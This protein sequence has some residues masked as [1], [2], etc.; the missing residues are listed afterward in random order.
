LRDRRKEER[1]LFVK[2]EFLQDM[3]SENKLLCSFLQKKSIINVVLWEPDLLPSSASLHSCSSGSKAPDKKSEGGCTI[4]S[5]QC[6][7][8]DKNN[9]SSDDTAYLSG[10]QC[11]SMSAD[12]KSSYAVSAS[13]EVQPKA[14]AN[15]EDYLP[16]D[17]SIDSGSLTCVACGILGFPFMAILQPSR[18]ALER[19]S[20]IH[21]KKDTENFDK[22]SS[23]LLLRCS[24][25]D[26]YG[27][28]LLQAFVISSSREGCI[29]KT[30][31]GQTLPRKSYMHRAALIL[32]A[33]LRL[34]VPK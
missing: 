20:N 32:P 22:D 2:Q 23:N 14:D 34:L 9:S 7:N 8:K 24:A 5:L 31:S 26:S 21:G 6:N 15:D 19:I 12:S 33:E 3:I 1:E 10:T 11:Q 13:G 30:Q 28:H 17:L 16:F 29:N 25:D 27:M 18:E 4:E